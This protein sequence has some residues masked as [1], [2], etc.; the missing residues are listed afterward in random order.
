MFKPRLGSHFYYISK[1]GLIPKY[2]RMLK[3]LARLKINTVLCHLRVTPG[4]TNPGSRSFGFEEARELQ[5]F[6]DEH[7]IELEA[8]YVGRAS[9]M[10]TYERADDED[11]EHLA[12]RG[13]I[14]RANGCPSNP[15]LYD[16]LFGNI[17]RTADVL[18]V[19]RINIGMDEMG[20]EAQGARWQADRR[21]LIR[22]MTGGELF[23]EMC[24]R[25]YDKIRSR[26]RK[27]DVLD[28]M[29]TKY[30]NDYYGMSDAYPWLPKDMGIEMWKGKT[31]D[32]GSNPEYG[33]DRFERAFGINN[34]G[35]EYG[36][37]VNENYNLQTKRRMWGRH[38]ATW[39]IG[40]T[41][42][43]QLGLMGKG[44]QV[45]YN[46]DHLVVF[47]EQTWAPQ[48]PGTLSL[49]FAQRMGTTILRMNE[50]SEGRRYPSLRSDRRPSFF[51]VP[52]A[53]N[54]NWSHI[55]PLP[56]D[57]KDW[58]DWGKNYDLSLLPMGKIEFDGVPFEILDPQQNAGRSFIFLS[59]PV[60]RDR[61]L[62]LPSTSGPIRIGRKAASLM[63]LRAH[64]DSGHAP[65][66][67]IT[68]E[69]GEYLSAAI[70]I[71][72]GASDAH[73]WN[74]DNGYDR[75]NRIKPQPTTTNE[76]PMCRAFTFIARPAWMG[77]TPSGD[78]ITIY[79]HEWVN[80]YPEK[81]IEAVTVWWPQV[82]TGSWKEALFAITGIEPDEVDVSF[83]SR[84][85][86]LPLQKPGAV[87]IGNSRALLSNGTFDESKRV[88]QSAE[89]KVIAKF[90]VDGLYSRRMGTIFEDK[91]NRVEFGLILSKEYQV[92]IEFT[93]PQ[94]V[95]KVLVRPGYHWVQTR[96]HPHSGTHHYLH[97]DYVLEVSSDGQSWQTLA[98]VIG[99]CGEDG[100]RVHRVPTAITRF[101]RL[102]LSGGNYLEDYERSY[103]ALS[104]LQVY[105]N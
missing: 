9:G 5:R 23:G 57:E 7:F 104:G 41:E 95:T 76:H 4:Q 31:G 18:P 81:T 85:E 22:E 100:D 90:K 32:K 68:Y 38:L 88:Y 10:D 62:P 78:E 43:T 3:A 63:F 33:I 24:V 50:I 101:L 99:A 70:P 84:R 105:K 61:T 12:K 87:S 69:G 71:L 30:G 60:E 40:D 37:E 79:A 6:A 89:G 25:L 56:A 92:Q 21:C 73:A 66:Y 86:R 83:W 97:I 49:E 58:L 2:K 98:E 74:S 20:H 53:R 64:A 15:K 27:T 93:N 47:A 54:C 16:G 65:V 34:T 82:R 44:R 13:N 51:T 96:P 46:M 59:N 28:T 11:Y 1:A 8:Y 26:N 17:D 29:L 77:H 19:T 52:M 67:R 75:H 94:P 55:D 14:A 39:G 48:K 103:P 102:R 72:A 35:R 91:D 36:G 45:G 42:A 80:P